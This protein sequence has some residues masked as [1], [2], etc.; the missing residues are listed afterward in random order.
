VEDWDL[1]LRLT[2]AGPGLGVVPEHL[3]EWRRHG[4]QETLTDWPVHEVA[5]FLV[6]E[7]AR[8]R[9]AGRRDPL[10]GR[11]Y[12]GFLTL[13][14]AVARGRG[15]LGR[16]W[17]AEQHWRRALAAHATGNRRAWWRE[18][19]LTVGTSPSYGP[20]WQTLRGAAREHSRGARSGR[21]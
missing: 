8:R 10:E 14:E 20:L 4:A 16:G 13:R 2:D 17:K 15:A 9:R 3:Y 21:A 7:S 1:F 18:M 5:M 11:D 19:L 6:R 12:E